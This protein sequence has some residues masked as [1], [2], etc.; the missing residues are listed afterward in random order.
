MKLG[1]FAIIQSDDCSST[2]GAEKW[3]ESWC[4]LKVELAKLA[5]GL[6]M[7]CL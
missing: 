3:T 4:S 7:R 6:D 2:G 1:A 5:V